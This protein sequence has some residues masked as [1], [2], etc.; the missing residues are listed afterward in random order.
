MVNC[1]VAEL[2]AVLAAL[3]GEGCAVADKRDDSEHGRIGWVMDPDDNRV[4]LWQPP[5]AKAE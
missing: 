5:A 2:D 1:V 3:K 4:E